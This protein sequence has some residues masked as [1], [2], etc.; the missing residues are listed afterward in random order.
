MTLKHK[1]NIIPRERVTPSILN[2]ASKWRVNNPIGHEPKIIMPIGRT[3]GRIHIQ[4]ERPM[5]EL[6]E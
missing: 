3:K 1:N 5:V 6:K 4:E 2:Y